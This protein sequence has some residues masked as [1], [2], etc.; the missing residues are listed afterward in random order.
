[1]PRREGLDNGLHQS[2][3]C[4]PQTPTAVPRLW[5]PSPRFRHNNALAGGGLLPI[6]TSVPTR[7]GTLPPW[8][9]TMAEGGGT[10]GAGNPIEGALPR[11]SV[12]ARRTAFRPCRRAASPRQIY[13]Y[14]ADAGGSV[15]GFP[16]PRIQK[17]HIWM[18]EVVRSTASAQHLMIW[19]QFLCRLTHWWRVLVRLDLNWPALTWPFCP[20]RSKD[21]PL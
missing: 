6:G 4:R 13:L 1:M 20:M 15:V 3:P 18:V 17:S 11:A 14:P 8:S 7:A 9:P 5:Y 10:P 12:G 21:V 2:T 16:P 19:M